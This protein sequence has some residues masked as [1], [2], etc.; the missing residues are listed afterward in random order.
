MAPKATALAP[1]PPLGRAVRT[2]RVGRWPMV[3][4]DAPMIGAPACAGAGERMRFL[5]CPVPARWYFNA[6]LSPV[7]EP[8]ASATPAQ[9]GPGPALAPKA[10]A[11]APAPPLGRAVRTRR[12]GRWPMVSMDAQM[13]GAPACAGAGE[14][15]RFL[16][17]PDRRCRASEPPLPCQRLTPL[18]PPAGWARTG[19]APKHTASARSALGLGA[20]RPPGRASASVVARAPDIQGN[21]AHGRGKRGSRFPRRQEAQRCQV[22]PRHSHGRSSRTGPWPQRLRPVPDPAKRPAPQNAGTRT[23][24]R[25]WPYRCASNRAVVISKTR[26]RI[27]GVS[28]STSCSAP[29][30]SS[31][32]PPGQRAMRR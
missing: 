19:R 29:R 3:S 18:P 4:M 23:S 31:S 15:V 28:I 14:R 20:S 6:I 11:L 1:A 8:D 17:C 21:V 12:V 22:P 2:R 10:T 24:R 13:I 7:A 32:R 25:D 5:I 16:I 26:V 30:T 9:Q 27:S